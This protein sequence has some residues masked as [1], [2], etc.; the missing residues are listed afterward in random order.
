MRAGKTTPTAHA[1]HGF[2]LLELLVVI[3]IIAVLATLTM[4]IV[5]SVAAN[6]QVKATGQTL[7]KLS[8][9]LNQQWKAVIDQQFL[10]KDLQKPL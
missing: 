1:R 6:Q 7:Q 10:P 4:A 2:T 9:I 8:T 3:A 5:G